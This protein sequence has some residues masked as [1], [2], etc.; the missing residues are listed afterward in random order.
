MR[1]FDIEVRSGLLLVRCSGR[2]SIEMT[3]RLKNE[4]DMRL[5]EGGLT[6]FALELSRV[7][8]LDSSGIGL[9]VTLRSRAVSRGMDFRLLRPSEEVV[10]TLELVKLG[11]FFEYAESEKELDLRID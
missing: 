2:L 1:D 9:L 6:V 7:R 5:R 8:F 4:L 10:R 3:G 11:D